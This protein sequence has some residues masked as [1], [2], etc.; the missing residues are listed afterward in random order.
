MDSLPKFLE[1]NLLTANLTP[2]D[3]NGI[4]PVIQLT[5]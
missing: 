1:Y 5:K 3:S 4:S 2:N